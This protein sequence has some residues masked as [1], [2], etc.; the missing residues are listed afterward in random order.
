MRARWTEHRKADDPPETVARRLR[1]APGPRCVL[2]DLR[3][4]ASSSGL[5][6]ARAPAR[7]GAATRADRRADGDDR[8]AAARARDRYDVAKYRPGDV[9]PPRA[10]A[11]RARGEASG[12]GG[13]ARVLSRHHPAGR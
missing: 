11:D 8:R 1:G 7:R 13:G 5:L 10:Y 3:A 12:A 9:R 2:F 6:A 4:R